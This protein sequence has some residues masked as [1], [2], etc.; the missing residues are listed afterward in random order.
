MANLLTVIGLVL[1]LTQWLKEKIGLSGAGAE[2]ASFAIG[3]VAGFGYQWSISGPDYLSVIVTAVG[4]ALVPSGLYKFA[5]QS[6]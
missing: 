4:M 6:K 3:F 1:G 2:L 5:T